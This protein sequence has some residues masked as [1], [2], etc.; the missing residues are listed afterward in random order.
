MAA[1]VVGALAAPAVLPAA[2]IAG[3][4]AGA[5]GFAAPSLAQYTGTGLAR[6]V[7][8]QEAAMQRGETPQELSLGKAAL[9]A[10]P[11][12]V[13]DRFAL[14]KTFKGTGL[15]KLFGE[16]GK[17]A[18]ESVAR[19]IVESGAN[20]SKFKSILAGGG[21][22]IAAEIPNEVGQQIIERAQAGLDLTSDEAIKE[23]KEAAFGATLLGG[24]FGGASGMG[25]RGAGMRTAAG[26]EQRAADETATYT[27]KEADRLKSMETTQTSILDTIKAANER[28]A[29]RVGWQGDISEVGSAALDR[30]LNLLNNPEG[31]DTILGNMGEYFPGTPAAELKKL[32]IQ[33]RTYKQRMTAQIKDDQKKGRESAFTANLPDLL[34]EYRVEPTS[35]QAPEIEAPRPEFELGQQMPAPVQ[36]ELDLQPINTINTDFLKSYGLRANTA[37][38]KA[39]TG[40]DLNNPADVQSARTIITDA[41]ESERLSTKTQ[42]KLDE[43][44]RKESRLREQGELF[45]ESDVD[46]WAA[47]R[48]AVLAE[49]ARTN[50]NKGLMDLLADLEK[51]NAAKEEASRVAREQADTEQRAALAQGVTEDIT[52]VP[53]AGQLA[54]AVAPEVTEQ[55]A[56]GAG[57]P[58]EAGVQDTSGGVEPSVGVYDGN[59]GQPGAEDRGIGGGALGSVGPNVL[60]DQKITVDGTGTNFTANTVNVGFAGSWNSVEI[61]STDSSIERLSNGQYLV[62]ATIHIGYLNPSNFSI[63]TGNRGYD[64]SDAPKS[65]TTRILLNSGKTQILAQAA[66][67]LEK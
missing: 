58:S 63:A 12:T 56:E 35:V 20:P 45:T 19:K 1:P 31:V 48:D 34:G 18:V 6:Q 42:E 54:P 51:E 32:Q 7:E 66:Q 50:R 40:L 29:A 62:T 2:G 5:I 44:A 3:L 11:A 24:P 38:S 67:V 65:I 4:S 36:G 37:V 64:L 8:E 17:D 25:M 59:V 15:G 49:E 52:Q 23:Y 43:L 60:I 13:L 47:E 14:G 57:I 46:K 41:L 10:I 33:L 55:G 27:K 21:R 9:G 39:L 22:G 28:E 26:W 61:T 16:E 30:S 53:F